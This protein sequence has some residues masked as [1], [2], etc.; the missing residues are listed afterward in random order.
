MVGPI[1]TNY[2]TRMIRLPS[3]IDRLLK[4]CRVP[5]VSIYSWPDSGTLDVRLSWLGTYCPLVTTF[6]LP[7][8]LIIQ[9]IFRRNLCSSLNNASFCAFCVQIGYYSS[10]THSIC[11]RFCF[12]NGKIYSQCA[13][14]NYLII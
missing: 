6:N 7:Y 10:C 3:L 11:H 4:N 13:S 1:Q 2:H 14:H 9:T 12:K 8:V 5:T